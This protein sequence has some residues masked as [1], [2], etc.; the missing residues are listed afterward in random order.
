MYPGMLAEVFIITQ[1]R[2]LFNYVFTPITST[3]EKAF[4]ER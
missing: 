1:S 4:N 3:F 2:T